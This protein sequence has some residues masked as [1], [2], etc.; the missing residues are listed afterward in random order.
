MARSLNTNG[1]EELGQLKRRVVRQESLGRIS[2]HDAKILTKMINELD[3]QIIKTNELDE[4]NQQQ[5]HSFN[6]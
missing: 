3:A 1:R 6:V 2:H 5:E 4:P